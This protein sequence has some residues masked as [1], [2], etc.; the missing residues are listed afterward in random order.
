MVAAGQLSQQTLSTRTHAHISTLPFGKQA[1]LV[2]TR[3]IG[4][5]KQFHL[6]RNSVARMVTVPL[7]VNNQGALALVYS[8]CMST[9]LSILF[10]S[11]SPL[12]RMLWALVCLIHSSI[13]VPLVQS[14][15]AHFSPWNMLSWVSSLPHGRP[16][17][18]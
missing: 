17:I 16:L 11:C 4:L 9:S 10:R 5:L 8:V 12:N 3:E 14:T 13:L 7:S 15:H 1:S 18:D 6:M 2:M